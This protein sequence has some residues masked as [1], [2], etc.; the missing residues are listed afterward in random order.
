MSTL[1]N[2]EIPNGWEVETDSRGN[3]IITAPTT[4]ERLG[5]GVTIHW[6]QRKFALGYG[7]RPREDATTF[8]GRGWKTKLVAAAIRELNSALTPFKANKADS[9]TCNPK[10]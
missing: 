7:V 3:S 10:E 9:T 1:F 5:G 4:P 6:Q 8:V 2:S